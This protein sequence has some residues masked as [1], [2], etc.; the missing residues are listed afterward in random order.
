MGEQPLRIL[1]TK[2]GTEVIGR[3]RRIRL[4]QAD[5]EQLVRLFTQPQRSPAAAQ[6]LAD[7]RH[8]LTGEEQA[9]T[10]A[11]IYELGDRVILSSGVCPRCLG[12]Q[13]PA[14]SR[15]RYG[16]PACLKS[17]RFTGNKLVRL[18][19]RGLQSIQ[20]LPE[21]AHAECCPLQCSPLEH[22]RD[23]SIDEGV[24]SQEL[25]SAVVK[26]IDFRFDRYWRLDADAGG[27]PVSFAGSSKRRVLED[28]YAYLLEY[29]YSYRQLSPGL[30]DQAAYLHYLN[31]HGAGDAEELERGEVVPGSL[32][33]WPGTE[34]PLPSQARYKKLQALMVVYL[35]E[36]EYEGKLYSA[37]GEDPEDG[38]FRV[39]NKIR[40]ADYSSAGAS[41]S[42]SAVADHSPVYR[43]EDGL[44]RQFGF[45][46]IGGE[47]G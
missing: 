27:R 12:L 3:K 11:E 37:I 17:R 23:T 8:K 7:L 31:R 44:S 30:T 26:N 32:A 1:E 10:E 29:C 20:S 14:A 18:D 41:P 22:L 2:D 24:L 15:V 9:E 39:W 34:Q 21:V 28:L 13:Y 6:W 43:Y 47:R 33:Y 46:L 19:S 16:L 35:I 5:Y 4:K 40:R 38:L 25:V 36:A 42:S 45:S